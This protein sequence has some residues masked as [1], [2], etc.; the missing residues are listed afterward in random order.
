M[1]QKVFRDPIHGNII[2]SLPR[3]QV[4]LDLIDTYEFQRLRRITQLGTSFLT[5]HGAEHSRMTHSLGVFHLMTVALDHL[6]KISSTKIAKKLE[7]NF[8]IARITALLHDIGHGPFSHTF[9]NLFSG[10]KQHE[11]WS[12]IIIKE[13]TSINRILTK[14][15]FKI[16]DI[17]DIIDGK[18]EIPLISELL[19]GHLDVDRM[20]YLLRDSH[21]TGV[22]YGVFDWERIV[23]S[24]E[25][26]H[27]GNKIHLAV[28]IKGL[29][30][31]EEFILAR[32]FMYEQ[33][34]LHKTILTSEFLVKSIFRR[35]AD[36]VQK[37]QLTVRNEALKA[38]FTNRSL[39]LENYML[40]DD[41]MLSGVFIAF[42]KEKDKIL[43]DLCDRFLKRRLL[44]TMTV[45]KNF[46]TFVKEV[47]RISNK[48][49][50]DADY[51]VGV[52]DN[53]LT[54]YPPYLS[55]SRKSV[56]DIVIVDKNGKTTEISKVSGLIKQFRGREFK[57]N[58][59]CF[60]GKI[61]RKVESQK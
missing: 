3:D 25:T 39:N 52:L 59:L 51:Y 38:L 20:D 2:L 32:F 37:G 35:A 18:F 40:L 10:M 24:L 45:E 53:S 30:S 49:G 1:P 28:N 8:Q 50:F 27:K 46:K 26:Y 11:Q 21:A 44:K 58:R 5:Y 9:E 22:K 7:K 23:A 13:K 60:P 47:R 55:N 14:Y 16:S 42:R 43:S 31:V 48:A 36:L 4:I 34:Y 29:H 17:I 54:P 6:I 12:K 41:H 33:V 56:K 61:K 19:S 57:E 15:G